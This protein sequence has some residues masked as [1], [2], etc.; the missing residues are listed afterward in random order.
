MEYRSQHNK[1]ADNV[2]ALC[3]ITCKYFL[4]YVDRAFKLFFKPETVS[5][6]IGRLPASVDSK[7]AKLEHTLDILGF[8]NYLKEFV[9]LDTIRGLGLNESINLVEMAVEKSSEDVV[10]NTRN[11]DSNRTENTSPNI[12]ID[13]N[14]AVENQVNEENSAD[15]K[16]EQLGIDSTKDVSN[17]EEGDSSL[18]AVP[19][20]DVDT[21]NKKVETIGIQNIKT[22]TAEH[23]ESDCSDNVEIDPSENIDVKNDTDSITTVELDH[24]VDIINT[25][26]MDAPPET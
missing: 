7:A 23:L 18:V 9:D 20:M 22:D 5:E 8:C 14:K 11:V 4:P 12:K 15:I 19:N 17:D 13:E 10:D 26:E 25:I 21:E 3:L 24:G 16:D 1:N 2:E 6:M